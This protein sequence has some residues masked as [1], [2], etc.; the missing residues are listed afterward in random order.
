MRK[1][2]L[3]GFLTALSIVNAT[4]VMTAQAAD[5]AGWHGKAAAPNYQGQIFPPWQQGANNPTINK[6][7]DFTV[8]EIAAE[9]TNRPLS[10]VVLTPGIVGVL[11]ELEMA[12]FTYEK[13]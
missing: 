6:G 11:P 7:F 9:V 2:R 12:G 3:A 1:V 13:L 5:F 8:P 4:S 10:N